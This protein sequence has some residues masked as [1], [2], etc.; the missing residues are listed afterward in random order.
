MIVIAGCDQKNASI[1]EL[2]RKNAQLQS[3]IEEQARM[4]KVKAAED[5]AAAQLAANEKAARKLAG[6]RAALE[7]EKAKLSEAQKTEAEE[8]LRRREEAIKAE[9][10]RLADARETAA[11]Q[12]DEARDRQ[13]DVTAPRPLPVAQPVASTR[14]VANNQTVDM[15]YDALDP[16]GDWMEVDG[17]GY[18]FQPNVAATRGWRPYTDGDWVRT[19]HGWTWRSNENFGWATYHYGR[20]IRLNRRGWVW[21]P[22][23][24]WAPA[25]VAWRH[26]DDYIGWAPLPPEAHSP[27]GFNSAVDSYYDIGVSSYVFVPHRQFCGVKTYAGR[28][29]EPERNVTIVRQTVNITNI[30]YQ[31][32]NRKTVLVNEGPDYD[33]VRAESS[34]PVP[35]LQLHR[36]DARDAH[37]SVASSPGG[38]ALALFAPM[39]AHKA[40][41]AKPK[42]VKFKEARDID[43]GWG[44]IAAAE[45]A[46]IR[47]RQ[48]AEAR[49]TEAQER[50]TASAAVRP[51]GVPAPQP[52]GVSPPAVIRKPG[53]APGKPAP[54][55]PVS[56]TQ[57]VPSDSAATPAVAPEPPVAPRQ[58]VRPPVGQPSASPEIKKPAAMKNPGAPSTPPVPAPVLNP[59]PKPVVTQPLS[60][61]EPELIPA[62]AVKAPVSAP[63]EETTRPSI[64]PAP[65]ATRVPVPVQK[66]RHVPNPEPLQT[67]NL[68]PAV[69]IPAKRLV[70]AQPEG[71]GLV[72]P[73]PQQPREISR[74]TLRTT[75]TPKG[76]P[77]E[78]PDSQ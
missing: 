8:N 49:Q 13:R 23:T 20:W 54:V 55:R 64:R 27:S 12:A 17:Y 75:P 38:G 29:I 22:G 31:T 65:A 35:V 39:L 56:S 58:A 14:Q 25:W 61:V 59:V 50:K 30:S 16:D 48:S 43:R 10:R 68:P 57:S 70:P 32:I 34:V 1:E 78:A 40:T 4:A 11:R 76:R 24:E 19:D 53:D 77:G 74:R 66:P 69:E 18:V 36:L 5:L 37:G 52:A 21:V 6:D 7:L 63:L 28:F 2:Q 71:A 47:E 15:F 72:R 26:N 9:E 60:V 45:Q 42:V 51:A 3:Q 33:R 44:G 62:P 67:P 46:A 41:A 73:N